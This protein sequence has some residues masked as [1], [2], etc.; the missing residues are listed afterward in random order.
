MHLIYKVISESMQI[1]VLTS[2]CTGWCP[3]FVHKSFTL[4][5]TR[6]SWS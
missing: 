1:W 4:Y 6:T 3:R 2:A 5:S